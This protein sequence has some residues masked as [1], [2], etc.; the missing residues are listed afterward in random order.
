[1]DNYKAVGEYIVIEDIPTTKE[2]SGMVMGNGDRQHMRTNEA[3]VIS[4][5]QTDVVK[6]GD[7][8]IYD[9]ARSFKV[10]TEGGDILTIIRINEVIAV[11][12]CGDAPAS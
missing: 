10:V 8:I 6:D 5:G 1:M 4:H 12:P 2:V 11:R 9:I 7:E 3:K